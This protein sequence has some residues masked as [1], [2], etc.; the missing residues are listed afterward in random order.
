MKKVSVIV[1]IYGVERYLRE[2]LDSIINQTLKD[3]EIILIND[4]SKDSCPQIID[5]YAQKDNRIITIHKPNGGY[6]NTCNIGLEKA[7]GE[8]ISIIEPDDYIDSNMF[9]DL[10]NLAKKNEAD[11]VKSS[12][13]DFYDT[14]TYKANKKKNWA[15][16]YEIPDRPFTIKECPFFLYFHPSIWS[17]IYKRE[18]LNKNNIRF[19][20]ASGAGWT[21]NPFQVQTLCLAQKIIYTDNAYYYWRRVGLNEANDI[22]DFTIPYKRTKEI[23]DW[24]DTNNIKDENI[25]AFLYKRESIYILL[26][27]ASSVGKQTL[28]RLEEIK[29]ISDLFNSSIMNNNKYITVIEKNDYNQIKKHP[30]LFLLKNDLINVMKPVINFI[31][32]LYFLLIANFSNR[33]VVFWGASV[34]LEQFIEKYNP[35]KKNLLGIIDKSS[36]RWGEKIGNFEVFSPDELKNLQPDFVALTVR[37]KNRIIFEDIKNYLKKENL[38]IKMFPNIWKIFYND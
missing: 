32:E 8:Y 12:F 29:K 2:C 35:K 18:F 5:E 17:C 26:L 27:L 3:I 22:K 11:I 30:L 19:I 31:V 6:G 10:Y 1:P 38:N 34:F 14:E 33:K 7:T 9:E 21:D 24:L 15:S 20:E 4:G 36:N 16:L 25:L 13:Y 28:K 37:Y 23:H